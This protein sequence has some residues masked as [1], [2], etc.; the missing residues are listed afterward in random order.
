M[1]NQKTVI[2]RLD[3]SACYWNYVDA[4]QEHSSQRY[5]NAESL[6]HQGRYS[7]DGRLRYC[8]RLGNTGRLRQDIF[9]NPIFHVPR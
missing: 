4:Q 6:S 7:Q 8:Q 1:I 2:F 3:G 9:G 5:Q